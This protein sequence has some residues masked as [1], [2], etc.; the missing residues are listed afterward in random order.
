MQSLLPVPAAE[1]NSRGAHSQ[2][3]EA[4]SVDAATI[5]RVTDGHNGCPFGLPC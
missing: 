5:R 2:S 3:V 4:N 1:T